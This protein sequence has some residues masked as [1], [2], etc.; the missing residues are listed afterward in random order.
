[1]QLYSGKIKFKIIQALNKVAHKYGYDY[2]EDSTRVITIKFKDRK[3]SRILHSCDFAIVN[4]Y[5]D[6]EGLNGK[7]IF[8]SIKGRTVTLGRNSLVDT[9]YFA[10]KN[11]G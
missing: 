6:E 9:I 4:N 1:M 3:N 11:S 2:A 7:N 10:K 5:T 8:V